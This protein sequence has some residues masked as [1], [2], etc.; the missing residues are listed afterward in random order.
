MAVFLDIYKAIYNKLSAEWFALH[1]D[2]LI[3]TDN[4]QFD[5]F[6]VNSAWLYV[7][8]NQSIANAAS[9]GSP[10]RTLI[11]RGGLIEVNIYTPLAQGVGLGLEY[12]SEISNIFLLKEFNGVNCLEPYLGTQRERWNDNGRWW[13]TPVFI[14]FEYDSES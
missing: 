1:P 13:S 8:I 9:V 10:G 3:V 14:P 11:R 2:L 4:M 6:P 7:S 5:A 12:A